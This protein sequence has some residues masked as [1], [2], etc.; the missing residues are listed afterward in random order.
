MLTIYWL[1]IDFIQPYGLLL[2]HSLLY[3][4]PVRVFNKLVL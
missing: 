3:S 4:L 1:T 2:I